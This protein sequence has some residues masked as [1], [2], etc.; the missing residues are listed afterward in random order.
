MLHAFFTPF[1]PTLLNWRNALVH[2]FFSSQSHDTNLM[3]SYGKTSIH[4][5]N[6]L[7]IAIK[8]VLERMFETSSK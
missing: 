6:E 1:H 4:L 8:I 2:V 3:T 5:F 7:F